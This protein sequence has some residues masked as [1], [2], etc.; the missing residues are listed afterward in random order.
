MSVK[1]AELLTMS[2]AHLLSLVTAV[3][4]SSSLPTAIMSGDALPDIHE[5]DDSDDVSDISAATSD[6]STSDGSSTPATPLRSRLSGE[7]SPFED[8]SQQATLEDYENQGYLIAFVITPESSNDAL[9]FHQSTLTTVAQR[10]S[11]AGLLFIDADDI[12]FDI[13]RDLFGS[14]SQ[15]SVVLGRWRYKRCAVKLYQE[16]DPYRSLD[17]LERE[18]MSLKNHM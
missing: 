17:A 13:H 3:A 7:E 5:E 6:A 1:G 9:R 12:T 11:D 10:L 4:S 15:A 2:Q 14:G 18:A 16:F 8:K